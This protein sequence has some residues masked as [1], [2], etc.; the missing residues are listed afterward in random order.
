MW[1]Q[2]E[3]RLG[4]YHRVC[5]RCHS[6][7]A[8]YEEEGKDYI[9]NEYP[10]STADALGSRIAR[11]YSVVK[12]KLTCSCGRVIYLDDVSTLIAVYHISNGAIYS[13]GGSA[14]GDW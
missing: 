7:M 2:C 3:F 5:P 9:D 6:N 8:Y 13:W 14:T 4:K 12:S 1:R 10:I 11:T